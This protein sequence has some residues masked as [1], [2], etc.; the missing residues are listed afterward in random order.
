MKTLKL[1]KW[2][3]NR[4]YYFPKNKTSSADPK[5]LQ[6]S[7]KSEEL[8]KANFAAKDLEELSCNN[9]ITFNGAHISKSNL[10]IYVSQKD[11]IKKMAQVKGL[12]QN[13]YISQRARGAYISSVCQPQV[14]FGLSHAT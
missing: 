9:P 5:Y 10:S 13:E 11:Q 14:A 12:N 3:S 6:E 7:N 8:K 2:T 1:P 4:D